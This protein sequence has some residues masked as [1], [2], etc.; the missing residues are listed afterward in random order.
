MTITQGHV[1]LDQIDIL[2]G[3]AIISVILLHTWPRE[4]LL[5]T[6]APFHIWQ[7]VPIFIIIAGYVGA[8]SYKRHQNS[9]L[10]QLYSIRLLSRRIK[11]I[12]VPFIVVFTIQIIYIYIYIYI[13]M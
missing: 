2:K 8:L 12:I 10:L 6:G 9:T 4:L 1:H 7:A 3:F 11:R 5:I 13:L